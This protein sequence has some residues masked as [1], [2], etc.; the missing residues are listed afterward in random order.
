VILT[1]VKSDSVIKEKG[2]RV[3][4]QAHNRFHWD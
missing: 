4:K 2:E 1:V 3:E